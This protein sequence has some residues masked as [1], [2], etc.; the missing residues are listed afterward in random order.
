[1]TAEAS[2]GQVSRLIDATG[3]FCPLPIQKLSAALREV[4]AGALVQLVSTDPGTPGDLQAFCKATHHLLIDTRV[5]GERFTA[6][7]RKKAAQP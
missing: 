3:L 5:E 7:V 4:E 2:A 6:L 1:M